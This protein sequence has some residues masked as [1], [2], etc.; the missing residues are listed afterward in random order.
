MTIKGDLAATTMPG[1]TA[2]DSRHAS[3]GRVQPSAWSASRLQD[4]FGIKAGHPVSLEVALAGELLG[5]RRRLAS[6]HQ[7]MIR[8]TCV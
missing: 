2:A 5:I 1:V 8:S 3:E 7:A 6:T 4:N